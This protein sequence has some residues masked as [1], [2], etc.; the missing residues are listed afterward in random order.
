MITWHLEKADIVKWKDKSNFE[1][2]NENQVVISLEPPE[3]FFSRNKFR[4]FLFW[5]IMVKSPDIEEDLLI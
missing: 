4:L 3:L 1:V 5:K 2:N